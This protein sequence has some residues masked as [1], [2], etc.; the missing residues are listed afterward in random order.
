MIRYKPLTIHVW[1]NNLHASRKQY[2]EW[3]VTVIRSE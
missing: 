3:S 1:L 2:E